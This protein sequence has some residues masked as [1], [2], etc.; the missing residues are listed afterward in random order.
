MKVLPVAIAAAA[1]VLTGCGGGSEKDDPASQVDW[2]KYSPAV[3]TR[4]AK[5]DKAKDC[6][7]LQKEFDSANSHQSTDLMSYLDTLMKQDGCY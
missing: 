5:L 7:G 3:K 4:I 2:S 6:K 1:L